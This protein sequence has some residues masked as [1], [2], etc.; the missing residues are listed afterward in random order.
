MAKRTASKGLK[1]KRNKRDLYRT[2]DPSAVLPLL[3]HLPNSVSFVEP[4]AGG[5]DLIRLL[6]AHGHV[7]ENAYDIKPLAEGIIKADA[8]KVTAKHERDFYI[9]NPVWTRHILHAMI[10]HWRKQRATWLLFDADWPH[11]EQKEIAQ[12]YG[13]PT[14]SELWEYCHKVV[15]VG[16]VKWIEGSKNC[17][18]DNCAWYLF[19]DQKNDGAPKFYHKGAQP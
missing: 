4:C 16:R 14:V 11:T 9:T 3:A 8:L 15:S 12:K 10:E 1:Y 13:V 18:M 17:G 19:T 2:T 7:C 6:E 5:G